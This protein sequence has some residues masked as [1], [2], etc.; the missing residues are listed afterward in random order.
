[1]CATNWALICPGSRVPAKESFAAGLAT[2]GQEDKGKQSLPDIASARA[3]D[4]R[5][6]TAGAKRFRGVSDGRAA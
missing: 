2:V 3:T 1:M 5:R 4:G 6:P